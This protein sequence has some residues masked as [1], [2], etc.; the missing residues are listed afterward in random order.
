[1]GSDWKVSRFLPLL[2]TCA[3]HLDSNGAN[4]SFPAEFGIAGQG[5][6]V[7]RNA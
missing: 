4:L 5:G 3:D 2:I 1:M 6:D 7:S